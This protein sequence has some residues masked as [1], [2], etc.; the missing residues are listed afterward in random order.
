MNE[1]GQGPARRIPLGSILLNAFVLPFRHIDQVVRQTGAPLALIVGFGLASAFAN[2]SGSRVLAWT[3]LAAYLLSTAW[4]AVTTH[5]MVLMESPGSP[6]RFDAPAIRRLA[7]FALIGA[8]LWMMYHYL[9]LIL[10]SL[11]LLTQSRY[12]A[13][14]EAPPAQAMDF[15]NFID[16]VNLA[17]SAALFLLIGRLALLLPA[18]ALDRKLGVPD[19]WRMTR[20]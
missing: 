8:A 20:G 2:A 16:V 12:V 10:I 5:R 13:A 3:L 17:G 6:L 9:R 11:A 15:Q 7:L 1:P 18:A 4:L 14:G 19:V